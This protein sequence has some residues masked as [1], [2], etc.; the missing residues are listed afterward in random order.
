MRNRTYYALSTVGNVSLQL[1]LDTASADLWVVSSQCTSSACNLPKYPLAFKSSSFVP[2][3]NNQTSF[4]VS[5]ADETGSSVP[6]CA[7]FAVSHLLPTGAQGFV[8]RESI[9]IGNITVPQQALGE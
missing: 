3:N 6:S 8:A 5:Y 4:S 2:V 7:R 9:S 1:A